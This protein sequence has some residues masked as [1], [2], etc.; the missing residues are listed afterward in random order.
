MIVAM[1]RIKE[2]DAASQN[3]PKRNQKKMKRKKKKEKNK[4]KKKKKRGV[5][6]NREKGIDWW[7]MKMTDAARPWLVS[8]AFISWPRYGLPPPPSSISHIYS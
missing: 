4:K 5:N 8:G 3:A 6:K 7:K 2:G 1:L